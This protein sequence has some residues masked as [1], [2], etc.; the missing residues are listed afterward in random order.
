VVGRREFLTHGYQRTSVDGIGKAAGVSKQTIYRHFNDKAEIL[1]AIVI[2]N[3]ARFENAVPLV[4]ERLGTQAV[5]ENCVASIRRFF[6]DGDSINLFR[7]GIAIASQ[8][9][10]LSATLNGYFVKS[11]APIADQVA[12]LDRAGQ[13]S[14]ISPLEGAAQAGVLAVEGVRYHMGFPAP[15]SAVSPDDVSAV[16]DLYLNGFLGRSSESWPEFAIDPEDVPDA[17]TQAIHGSIRTYFDDVSDLR[18][19]EED[20]QRLVGVARKMFFAAGY[21]DS[22]LDEIGPA[23]RIGRGTLY[24]WFGG[25]EALFRVSMLHAAS[26]IGARKLTLPK[27]GMP[28]E[29]TLRELAL[30]VSGGLCGRTGT[31]LYRTTIAE[32]DHDPALARTVYQLTR[33]KVA[34]ALIPV[35]AATGTGR[36]LTPGQLYWTAMQF[37]TLATDG[38]RYLSLDTRLNA[39]QRN[40]L[41]ERVASSFLYGRRNL[42]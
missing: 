27:A 24:R 16:A 11:L 1:R 38:N 7:L 13:I 21:R 15:A 36:G 3:S 35:L 22:S 17:R 30:W 6:F 23:A 5:I 10:E 39:Q 31:Q 18:L 32:A 19:G 25:K 37:I 40:A 42:G 29:E 41:A 8:L 12:M 28:I 2:Q 34:S 14:V 4:S 33:G 20:L 9:P 26:E